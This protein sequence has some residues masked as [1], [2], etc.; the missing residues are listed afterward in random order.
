MLWTAVVSHVAFTRPR[1]FAAMLTT[2]GAC[3]RDAEAFNGCV[4]R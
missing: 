3:G 1:L 2:V 4:L